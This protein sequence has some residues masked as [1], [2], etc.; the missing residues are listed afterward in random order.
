MKNSS[1][2]T[3][4]TILLL[5]VI[6]FCMSPTRIKY[7]IFSSMET[8]FDLKDGSLKQAYNS[9]KFNASSG[10]SGDSETHSKEAQAYFNEIC[11]GDEYGNK[12]SK[13]EPIKHDV[14][15][16][17]EGS[18]SDYMEEELED[19]VSDLNSLID[20]IEIEIVSS[21]SEANTFVY[22]G[23]KSGFNQNYPFIDINLNGSWGY[24]E[25]R[26]NP[27]T[28]TTRSFIFVDML[29]TDGNTIAQR[30]VLREELTQSLGF[31][32]DSDKYPNSIFYQYGNTVTE[33]S[34]LDKEI[35]QMLY[36]E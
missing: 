36:N 8:L 1:I 6:G 29:D 28:N 11:L 13:G 30:S 34:D 4:T 26:F 31:T 5:L 10:T 19:I 22:L 12:Y 7:R 15:I 21:K 27:K 3:S 20:P 9:V 24:F 18:Q 25:T 33:Y 17:V 16:F 23:S 32:N 35:I 14:K 2:S